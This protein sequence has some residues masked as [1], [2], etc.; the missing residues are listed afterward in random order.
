MHSLSGAIED[1]YA[2]CRK[3]DRTGG[4]HVRQNKS[5]SNRLHVFFYMQKLEKKTQRHISEK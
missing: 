5:D 1:A 3:T 2:I 4:Y